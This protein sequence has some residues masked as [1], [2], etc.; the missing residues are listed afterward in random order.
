MF[1]MLSDKILIEEKKKKKVC[2]YV[3]PHTALT[4]TQPQTHNWSQFRDEVLNKSASVKPTLRDPK[5]QNKGFFYC[6]SFKVVN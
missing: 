3:N 6:L 2:F 1:L 4:K 5:W